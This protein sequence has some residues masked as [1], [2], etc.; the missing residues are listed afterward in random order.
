MPLCHIPLQMALN[1]IQLAPHQHGQ[2]INAI[3]EGNV[4]VLFFLDSEK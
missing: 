3:K 1:H 4:L 2:N